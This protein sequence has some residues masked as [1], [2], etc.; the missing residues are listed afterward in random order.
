MYVCAF[1]YSDVDIDIDI[2][3]HIDI[4]IDRCRLMYIDKDEEMD[5]YIC[6]YI[7]RLIS[8]HI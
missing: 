4:G 5:T 8:V 2:H 1:T 6:T 7:D 3:I